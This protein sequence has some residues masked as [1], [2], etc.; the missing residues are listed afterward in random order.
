MQDR[1]DLIDRIDKADAERPDQHAHQQVAEHGADAQKF[2]KRRRDHGGGEEQ[3]RLRQGDILHAPARSSANSGDQR[4]D[5]WPVAPSATAKACGCPEHR[6]STAPGSQS[7]RW[8][9]RLS[10]YSLTA[11]VIAET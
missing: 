8:S 7:R 4:L 6:G 5:T 9:R 2:G 10:G 11:P 3:R 1:A